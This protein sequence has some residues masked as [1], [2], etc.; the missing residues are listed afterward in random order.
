MV[1]ESW[2]SCDKKFFLGVIGVAVA[3]RGDNGGVRG[4]SGI[5]RCDSVGLRG[6]GL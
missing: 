2:S 4:D 1:Q 5:M 6:A 3:V